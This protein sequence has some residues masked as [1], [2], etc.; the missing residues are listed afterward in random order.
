MLALLLEDGRDRATFEV[1][2]TIQ[3]L[4]AA[5]LDRLP[6]KERAA[7]EAASVEG[8]VF[9]EASVAELCA[10]GIADVHEALL[11]LV[12]RDMIRQ[13]RPVFS[14]ERAYRFRHLLIRDAAYES[15]P[16]EARATL[17][18]RHAR[19]LEARFDDRTIELDEIVGYHYEQAFQYRAELGSIDDQTRV[20]GRAAAERLGTAG[21]RAFVRS[22][23]PA[24]V[25][26]VSRAVAL[27][28]AD[29]PLRVELV[30]NVR[31][32]QGMSELSE[33]SWADRVLTEA[34]E[35]AAT[36]GD[37]RLASHALV[38]RGLLRLFTEADVTSQEILRTARQAIDAFEVLGDELA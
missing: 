13:D 20:L 10:T 38:Q 16:K 25:N 19:L 37:R 17:H 33:L 32:V 8:K 1:P 29:D 23:V 31:V 26:L 21:R 6:D 3:A 35:A 28:G 30:P 11:E 34:V 9:H 2:A 27:L 36:T 4:L 15:I 24:G 14:G 22:D 7:I 5:R 12:R 18:E